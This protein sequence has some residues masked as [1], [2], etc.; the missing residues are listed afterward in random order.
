M[1]D[2]FLRY[3][4]K[5]LSKI[6]SMRR[7]ISQPTQADIVPVLNKGQVLFVPAAMMENQPA[8]CYNCGFYNHNQSCQLIGGLVR[9]RKFTYPR[10][11]TADAKRIEYWPC[12][13][14]HSFG[15]PNYGPAHYCDHPSDP[16][17]LDLLWIN[18][19]RPGQEQGG[20]NCG[21]SNGG[22]DCDFYMTEGPDKRDEPTGFCRVLQAEV[23]NGDVCAAWRDDDRL[24]WQQAQANLKELGEFDE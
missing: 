17:D 22:D 20:A 2:G 13:G 18:A 6:N 7:A 11:A 23:A 3:K 9:I 16:S 15:E 4:A 24:T 21:G 12:C 14:M 1:N 8:S 19:P 10:E 5:N